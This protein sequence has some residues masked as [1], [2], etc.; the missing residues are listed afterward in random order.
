MF[1]PLEIALDTALTIA[2]E[3]AFDAIFGDDM[4]GKLLDMEKDIQN[5]ADEIKAETEKIEEMLKVLTDITVL[6]NLLDVYRDFYDQFSKV[7]AFC[8]NNQDMC[9]NLKDLMINNVDPADYTDAQKTAVQDYIDMINYQNLYQELYTLGGKILANDTFGQGNIF[10]VIREA[11]DTIY[12]WAI[13]YYDNIT[14]LTSNI[15]GTYIETFR[16]I[17][18]YYYFTDK[19]NKLLDTL[20]DQMTQI[21]AL[22]YSIIYEFSH[23]INGSELL[24]GTPFT[25]IFIYTPSTK[26]N[27]I[28]IWAIYDYLEH[29]LKL[30]LNEGYAVGMNNE[31]VQTWYN[32]LIAKQYIQP[33][34]DITDALADFLCSKL[35]SA[36]AYDFVMING[37]PDPYMYI[38][39]TY[40][41]AN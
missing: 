16:Q 13:D 27:S 36:E 34:D 19:T 24:N 10:S 8:L 14:D 11:N 5:T 7:F 35:G 38:G 18:M 17:M 6:N 1:K 26:K 9:N 30:P 28:K 20:T 33:S 40:P 39:D 21:K 2:G 3:H 29:P 23:S 32:D 41:N 12:A 37:S 15:V 4:D 25:N 22:D 31:D